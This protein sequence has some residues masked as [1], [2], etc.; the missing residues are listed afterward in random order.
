MDLL[1]HAD[2]GIASLGEFGLKIGG[3]EEA[4]PA[5]SVGAAGGEIALQ[6][7]QGGGYLGPLRVELG[8]GDGLKSIALGTDFFRESNGRVG[9]LTIRWHAPK[10]QKAQQ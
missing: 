7:V 3:S 10:E 2:I 4:T 5:L 6:A 1:H 8:I 9:R